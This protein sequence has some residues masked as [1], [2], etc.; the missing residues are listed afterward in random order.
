MR[1][2]VVGICTYIEPYAMRNYYYAYGHTRFEI[3]PHLGL[4]TSIIGA[5]TYLS[6]YLLRST[7][8]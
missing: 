3:F 5:E 7:L 2:H 4:H 6:R 8:V 1:N